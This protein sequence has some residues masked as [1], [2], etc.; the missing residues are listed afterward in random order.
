M[1]LRVGGRSVVVALSD[2]LCL[3]E[4]GL[5]AGAGQRG[6]V[7]GAG[8]NAGAQ[9]AAEESGGESGLEPVADRWGCAGRYGFLR[10]SGGVPGGPGGVRGRPG[11]LQGVRRTGIGCRGEGRAARVRRP[12][13]ARR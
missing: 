8:G 2:A 13:T 7:V 1:L 11:V 12:C 5:R 9:I 4:S 3:G 6:G 10:E